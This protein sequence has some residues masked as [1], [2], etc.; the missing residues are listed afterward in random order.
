MKRVQEKT[1]QGIT[2]CQCRTNRTSVPYPGLLLY[3]HYQ[4]CEVELLNPVK[5]LLYLGKC[6]F[7]VLTGITDGLYYSPEKF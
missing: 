4:R 2:G 7:V 5:P 1:S 3:L 6:I